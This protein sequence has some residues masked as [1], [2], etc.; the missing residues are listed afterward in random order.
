MTTVC[1]AIYT[2]VVNAVST[3]QF[4]QISEAQ[5]NHALLIQNAASSIPSSS[6][7]V[8]VRTLAHRLGTQFS[9]LL[10]NNLPDMS[11]VVR[12][13]RIAWSI[14]ANGTLDM[15]SS[16]AEQI[17][18]CLVNKS[19]SPSDPKLIEALAE[20]QNVN[21]CR[22]ALEV[23][24][25]T[26]CLVPSGLETLNQEKH[27]R[28][29]VI[30]LILLCISRHIRQC[31]GEQFL[32]IALKCSTQPNRP[33]QFFIQLLFTCLH[34]FCKDNASHSQE[35]FYLLCRLLNCAN[36]NNVPISNTETLLNNEIVWLKKLKQAFIGQNAS[37]SEKQQSKDNS[38]ISSLISS[39]LNQLD[40]S[41]VIDEM[42][43]DGHLCITKELLLFQNSEKKHFVGAHP[44]GP[45][46]INDLV[47]YFIFPASFLFK[48]YRDAL[49]AVAASASPNNHE[50]ESNDGQQS[51]QS[52]IQL[53]SQNTDDFEQLLANKSLKSICNS[54]MTTLSAFDLLVSLGS[55]C[56]PNLNSLTE[57]I[58]QL[59]YP[60]LLPQS[61]Q[62]PRALTVQ[63]MPH[64]PLLYSGSTA[65]SFL[66][67]SSLFNNNQFTNDCTIS[68]NEWEYIPPIGQRPLNGF[69]GLK[70]AGATCYM[71]SV[72]QQLFM[73]RAIRNSLLGVDLSLT[74]NVQPL[75]QAYA[76]SLQQEQ[77]NSGDSI[78]Q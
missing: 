52:Q 12:V 39:H 51:L 29:F 26:L 53:Q 35:Y 6:Q 31:A 60:S 63:A 44:Q 61:Q 50:N 17:H 33:I 71:N 66:D 15:I 55:G 77:P 68:S 27:W 2:Y 45:Q 54:P 1:H 18:E 3:K 48:K 37:L 4:S 57:L 20:E 16:S 28:T 70:N 64:S 74:P 10:V 32:L 78:S 11:H 59:F 13:Q 47:E 69:V 65:G 8:T 5:H 49:V 62:Q 43:L 75:T 40:E 36:I 21:V 23:L 30:D 7:E 56:L 58:F 76:N 73:V 67:N 72:L 46:L 38:I 22:E 25:L 14:A 9:N 19:R 42:L 41:C 34:T 24:T